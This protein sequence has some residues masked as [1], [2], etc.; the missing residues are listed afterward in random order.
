MKATARL[1]SL[2]PLVLL[3]GCSGQHDGVWQGY[4]EGEYVYVAAPV[5]GA[6]QSLAV[7]RGDQVQAGQSLFALDP[8]PELAARGEAEQR[9]VQ[10]V[11]RLANLS[12]GMRPSEI[13]ALEARLASARADAEFAGS[14]VRRFTQLKEERV[15]S[16]DEMERAQSRWDAARATVASLEANLETA[17]LGG[18]EDEIAAAA[19]E[20][21]SAKFRL[22]M[23][24]W[25]VA[26]KQQVAFT[27]GR[28]EDTL[29]REGEWV[30][31][32]KPVVSLL[33][34][35]NLK[36][37]FFVSETDLGTLR[38]GQKVTVTLDGRPDPVEA[39]IN[40]IAAQAEFTPPVIYS[41]ENRAKLVFMVE[42]VFPPGDLDRLH[43][44]QPVDVRR[45]P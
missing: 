7:A 39:T 28:V 37:R 29:Y 2:L 26:Q 1:F 13:A 11:A 9:V 25:A 42:A 20:V 41:R 40:Y 31:A 15:I 27:N 30:A 36:T 45:V 18:R 23:A 16:P 3:L 38:Q 10:A 35:T 21:E 6:L 19:S 4:I 14:E 5:S 22:E 17:R 34:P 43:P 12:K 44:G 24:D 33:P 8:E 32:G